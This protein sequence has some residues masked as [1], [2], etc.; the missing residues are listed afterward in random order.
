MPEV[1]RPIIPQ[2]VTVHLASPDTPAQNVTV[3]FVEYIK[4][5]LLNV[6][7]LKNL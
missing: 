2:N 5:V 1:L 6:A 4:N 7:R 3:D